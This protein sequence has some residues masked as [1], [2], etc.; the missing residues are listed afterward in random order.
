MFG[1]VIDRP[2]LLGR[3]GVTSTTGLTKPELGGVTSSIRWAGPVIACN[4]NCRSFAI[5]LPLLSLTLGTFGR[6]WDPRRLCGAEGMLAFLN[7]GEG[8][9][10]MGGSG[11]AAREVVRL[12][13]ALIIRV[14]ERD[15]RP[16]LRLPDFRARARIV[17]ATLP[18]PLSPPSCRSLSAKQ[19]AS[20][21]CIV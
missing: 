14:G 6:S 8:G 11:E 21:S 16:G 13:A 2:R 9:R 18:N 5:L 17:F 3:V 4:L 1:W 12:L 7:V 15:L 20:D 10:V 19:S